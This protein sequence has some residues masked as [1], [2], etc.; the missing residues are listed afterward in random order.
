MR[1]LTYPWTGCGIIWTHNWHGYCTVIYMDRFMPPGHKWPSYSEL[2][3]FGK[4]HFDD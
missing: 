1:T 2:I 4:E 3:I